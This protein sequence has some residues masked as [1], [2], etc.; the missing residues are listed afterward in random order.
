MARTSPLLSSEFQSSAKPATSVLEDKEFTTKGVI[1]YLPLCRMS[2]NIDI[3]SVS[4]I[5]NLVLVFLTLCPHPSLLIMLVNYHLLTL[6]SPLTFAIHLLVTYTLT[7]LAFSSLIV[8][9]ARNPGP[10]TAEDT[11]DANGEVD[12]TEALMSTDRN[13]DDL[14]APGK[15]C[16]KCWVPKPERVS[17]TSYLYFGQTIE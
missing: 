14:S 16:R 3:M 15:F 8:C 12:F 17:V 4:K 11:Q 2:C 10:V 13:G 9:I 5:I 7:F 6:H 1:H